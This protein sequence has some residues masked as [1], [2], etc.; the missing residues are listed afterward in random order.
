MATK[1]PER[2]QQL[3]NALVDVAERAIAADGLAGVKARDLAA[4]AGCSLGAIYT[5]FPNLD[6]L[7]FAVNGRTLAQIERFLEDRPR[8]RGTRRGPGGPAVAELVR[9]ALGYLDYAARNTPR[10]RALFDH[11]MSSG[12]EHQVPPWYAEA[13]AQLFGLIEEPLAE[14]WPDLA[15]DRCAPLARTLFSGVHGIV[16]LGLDAKLVALPLDVLKD[17]LRDF[18]TIVGAGLTLRSPRRRSGAAVDRQ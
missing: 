10:W 11:R 2:H 13:Q 8:E 17:Q 16:S 14:L 5:V 1:T 12:E 6:A 9:L 3:R 7:I 18:V 4:A 15:E